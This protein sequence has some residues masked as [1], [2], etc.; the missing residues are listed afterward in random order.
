[1]TQPN[2]CAN[3]L[4][5]ARIAEAESRFQQGHFG[6]GYL[7]SEPWFE[8]DGKLVKVMFGK[9]YDKTIHLEARVSFMQGT[10][11]VSSSMVLNITEALAEDSSWK[12]M[13]SKWRHGGWYVHG[14]T[15]LNGGCGC[16]S[17][18]YV[19]G[20]WRIVCDPRRVD[21]NEPGDY[22]FKTRQEAAHAERALI[23]ELTLAM[24]QKRA[25]A[26]T[27]PC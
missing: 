24:L 6:Y 25:S 13:F 23:R 1:M 15:H 7:T 9:Q 22:T 18:N 16:V 4:L 5:A 8:E 14:I 12:P 19:D 3:D 2:N 17:N 10:S 26:I 21:V 27:A 11:K 20:M